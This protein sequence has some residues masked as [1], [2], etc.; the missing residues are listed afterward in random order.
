MG[1]AFK[2]END[3]RSFLM[4][5]CKIALTN[6]QEKV[7]KIVD[8]HVQ[9]FYADYDPVM[10][11]RTYQLM[12]SLVKSNIHKTGSGYEAEVYFDLGSIGYDTGRQPSGE[13]V[14]SAAAY[15]GHGA[16]G[17]NIVYGGGADIWITPIDI[18]D[19]E[20]IN[21]LVQELR[22]AGIPIK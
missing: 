5:K 12:R 22:A 1:K 10:Y 7:Y 6:A 21:I 9:R 2:N 17:L 8:L 16:T 3:L 11:E 18:L 19:M 4:Q 15:G 20:A 14:V 13:Q